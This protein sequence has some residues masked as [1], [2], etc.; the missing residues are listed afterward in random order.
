MRMATDT[1]IQLHDRANAGSGHG[2]RRCLQRAAGNN[3]VDL[4]ATYIPQPRI[5]TFLELAGDYR[6]ADVLAGWAPKDPETNAWLAGEFSFGNGFLARLEHRSQYKL[7]GSR[8]FKLGAHDL[9]V[10]GAGYYGFSYLPGLVPT[11]VPVSGDT[12]D[13]RQ[14]DRTHNFLAAV[15]DTWKLTQQRQFVLSG[16][17]RNYGLTLRSFGDGLI[18]QVRLATSSAARRCTSRAYD[19][20][21]RSRQ[22][23]ISAAMRRATS[24]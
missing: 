14:L 21:Y 19:R 22:D 13:N 23:S 17:F 5:P 6:D 16:F 2:R 20:G 9:T 8:E 11:G 15:S 7:N 24:T 10:F 1:P 3:S 18:Q 12:I 4:A